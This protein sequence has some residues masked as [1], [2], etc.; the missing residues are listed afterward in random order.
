MGSKSLFHESERNSRALGAEAFDRREKVL[1]LADYDNGSY[2][3]QSGSPQT[4]RSKF[5]TPS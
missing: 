3:L 1:I 2:T 5:K 4:E